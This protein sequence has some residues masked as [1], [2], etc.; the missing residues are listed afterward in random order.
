MDVTSWRFVDIS[1][2]PKGPWSNFGDNNDFVINAQRNPE[3][4]VSQPAGLR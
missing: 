4:V 1:E 3:N 2:V